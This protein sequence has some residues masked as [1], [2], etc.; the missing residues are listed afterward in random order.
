MIIKPGVDPRGIKP[1]ILLALQVVEGVFLDEGMFIS[2]SFPEYLDMH[3]R[4]VVTSIC[5]GKHSAKSYHRFGYAVDIRS[6]HI[7]TD[8]M[9]RSIAKECRRR[10]NGNGPTKLYDFVL[11]GLGSSNEHYHMEFDPAI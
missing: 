5:D 10:L 4:L 1:E 9:K 2:P 7:H 8:T 3:E 11:E 6:K